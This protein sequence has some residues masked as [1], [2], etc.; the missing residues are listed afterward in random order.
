[1]ALLLFLLGGAAARAQCTIE[2]PQTGQATTEPMPQ[3]NCLPAGGS[4]DYTHTINFT[5]AVGGVNV[6]WGDGNFSLGVGGTSATHTYTAEGVFTYTI[7]GCGGTVEG[8]VVNIRQTNQIPKSRSITDPAG[9]V[10]NARCVPDDLTFDIQPRGNDWRANALAQYVVDWGDG[11]SEILDV[12]HFN[13]G[14]DGLPAGIPSPIVHTYLPDMAG[15]SLSVSFTY[16]NA[17]G[18][19]PSAPS[20]AT[21]GEYFFLDVDTAQAAPD[22][23]VICEPTDVTLNATPIFNCIDTLPR[24]IRW[25]AIEDFASPTCGPF[26]DFQTNP[27]AADPNVRDGFRPYATHQ[28]IDIPASCLL[29]VPA[30]STYLVRMILRNQCG[31][32][33]TTV[34]IIVRAP[35]QAVV[36]NNSPTCPGVEMEFSNNTPRRNEQRYVWDW[37]DGSDLETANGG[38]VR[39]L[40]ESGGDYWVK[41]TSVVNTSYGP[42]CSVVDSFQVS[43]LK[44][45]SPSLEVTPTKACDSITVELTNTSRF[46][47]GATW[48]DWSLGGDISVSPRNV[49]LPQPGT[50]NNNNDERR[51]IVTDPDPTDSSVTLTYPTWGRYSLRV[52]AQSGSCDPVWSQQRRVFVYP[53]PK[54]N[55]AISDTVLCFGNPLVI[56]DSSR[57]NV[58]SY[59]D[60]R[61]LGQ[62]AHHIEWALDFGGDSTITGRVR[63]SWD[64][65][66]T[67]DYYDPV[68]SDRVHS[69]TFADTGTYWVKIRVWTNHCETIDSVR[70]RVIP[71]AQPAFDVVQS[72]CNRSEFRLIN[73]TTPLPTTRYEWIVRRG[74]QPWDTIRTASA[75]DTTVILPHYGTQLLGLYRVRLRTVTGTD[76]TGYCYAETID[77]LLEVPQ[78]PV[79]LFRATPTAGCGDSLWV[80]FQNQSSFVPAG[81][82]FHWEFDNGQSAT[83]TE[84]DPVPGQWFLNTGGTPLTYTVRMRLYPDGSDPSC[85]Y[86]RT[87]DITVHPQAS[88]RIDGPATVCSGQPATFG[89]T[90]NF[91]NPTTL[92]WG[93]SVGGGGGTTFSPVFFNVT[94]APRTETI[95][96]SGLNL[97]GCPSTVTRVVTV[98]PT[99]DFNLNVTPAEACAGTPFNFEVEHDSLSAL[100]G[101]FT[102]FWR[103]GDGSVDTTSTPTAQHVYGNATAGTIPYAPEVTVI[104]ANGCEAIKSLTVRV[105]PIV[106]ADFTPRPDPVCSGEL[107]TLDAGAGA[108]RY[109]W[110]FRP[111][112]GTWS[113]PVTAGENYTPVPSPFVNGGTTPLDYEIR[114]R[115]SNSNGS[116]SDQA[117]RRIT[118]Q[119]VPVAAFTVTPDE[120]C[121]PLEVT[122]D[123]G[124]SQRGQRYLW[125][126]GDGTFDTTDTRTSVT[127]RYRNVGNLA[128]TVFV[129]LTVVADTAG[130]QC[131]TSTFKRVVVLPEVQADFDLSA[132]VGCDPLDV[133]F[134]NQSNAAVA[135][136]EWWYREVGA[137]N[138]DRV[139]PAAPM[140]FPFRSRSNT[141]TT[142]Y[143]IRLDVADASGTC[144]AQHFDTVAVLP[145]P[146]VQFTIDAPTECA[147][148]LATF[149]NRATAT[150]AGSRYEYFTKLST[151]PASAWQRF[152][153]RTTP[154]GTVERLFTNN[155][156]F[157]LEYDVKLVVTNP[158][159]CA[160][161]VLQRILV[162][163]FVRAS[164]R[165]DAAAG[166]E[167]LLVQFTNLSTASANSFEWDFDNPASGSAN[168]SE[169]RNPSHLFTEPGEYHVRLR[170]GT[171]N[172]A[173]TGCFDDTT[174]TIRVYEQPIADVTADRLTGCSGAPF[175]FNAAG[176]ADFDDLTWT[177][178]GASWTTSTARDTTFTFVNETNAPRT[179]VVRVAAQTAR[180]CVAFDSVQVIVQPAVAAAFDMNRDASC[181]PLEV[182][183]TENT[184]G[185]V[186]TWV[187]RFDH[188][189]F[190]PSTSTDRNPRASF[191]NPTDTLIRVPISLVVYSAAAQGC[192][193]YAYDTVEVYPEPRAQ[194][195]VGTVTCSPAA[196]EF[197]YLD[198]GPASAGER[199]EWFVDGTRQLA[200]TAAAAGSTVSLT[201]LNSTSDIRTFTVELR[202][203]NQWGCRTQYST[204]VDVPPAVTA[205]F[206]PVDAG[207]AP[208]RVEFEN[209]STNA[210]FFRWDFGNGP[211]SVS[212]D[213]NPTYTY[214]TPGTYTVTL[215]AWYQGDRNLDRCVQTFTQDIVVN[216]VPVADPTVSPTGAC[217]DFG[218][219]FGYGPGQAPGLRKVWRF[220]TNEVVTTRSDDPIIRSF[221]NNTS[222]P[223]DYVQWLYVYSDEGC[224][225]SASITVRVKPFVAAGFSMSDSVACGVL[226]TTFA[227][228]AAVSA[229]RFRWVFDYSFPNPSDSLLN[230]PNT[231]S[232]T[233]TFVNT[234]D[235]VLVVPVTLRAWRVEDPECYALYYDEVLIYPTPKAGFAFDPPGCTPATV[236]FDYRDARP[237]NGESYEWNFDGTTVVVDS[238]TAQA[239]LLPEAFTFTNPDDTIRA[240]PVTL[241]ARNRWGCDTV[242]TQIVY[243]Q[244]AITATVEAVEDAC[245]P[246]VVTFGFTQLSA[247]ARYFRWD[248][249]DGNWSAERTPT[250]RYETDRDTT[251]EATLTTWHR[252]DINADACVL[253]VDVPVRVLVKPEAVAQVTPLGCSGDAFRFEHTVLTHVD[254]LIW[255]F[256]D[257]ATLATTDPSAFVKVFTN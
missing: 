36:T 170:V 94:D 139:P 193:A 237:E 53:S 105:Q 169:L 143:E 30:D 29:P 3:Y 150:V 107:V 202:T 238:A 131:Q 189:V 214:G 52:R 6:D 19:D 83:L 196:V 227:N 140:G 32:D 188:P 145:K 72:T 129:T 213:R 67:L 174:I 101:S 192:R 79:A 1:M 178:D 112:G 163:P 137:T 236:R 10:E 223:Q 71:N 209:L 63:A 35:R 182:R 64:D 191:V 212:T 54:V 153:N 195:S 75:A 183:F 34:P 108:D 25:Q 106:S 56:R 256:S 7:S 244:P 93:S 31:D 225:D 146:E 45:V 121:S 206:A 68:S 224:V 18:L 27:S 226:T 254:S 91:L 87:Q 89:A 173:A 41:V 39:H 194:F 248:F 240:F 251:Y 97:F 2:D 118:V 198:R 22:P 59:E 155:E 252:A 205:A 167:D 62:E 57:V 122:F 117:V 216:E 116:C 179:V 134:I 186:D 187:W 38:T 250:H 147:D 148:V 151:A 161:S 138:W 96:L 156:T 37:G 120:G 95:T 86:E 246:S 203:R 211:G 184:T 127:H 242:G 199:Y 180:G 217:S 21:F 152:S 159:G 201:L 60:A 78:T 74:T 234:S 125:N 81:S 15:C 82:T 11:T 61:G 8:I 232:V 104:S 123:P 220:H 200:E 90:G 190:G 99:L 49:F 231:Q 219:R 33:T 162:K 70:V 245:E 257:G 255:H 55:W 50:Y 98:L 100:F 111:V 119:P 26:A 249:G 126:F 115:A 20:V 133:T 40:Y 172:S 243:V 28:S 233:R 43:V 149:D 114:L 235:T 204:T 102:Y 51:V 92:A 221:T 73:N 247:S 14:T 4:V 109:E 130:L 253:V 23:V 42:E 69:H 44:T 16:Q 165:P 88:L 13:L 47:A 46:T 222:T 181:T 9:G 135:N 17:C 207:C 208:L 141:D 229:N 5:A 171:T 185:P 128:Q 177:V 241:V 215:E 110:S 230:T 80:Q 176:S 218:F 65:A 228:E 84:N 103:W 77:S 132:R 166:C 85:F 144:T 142:W 58:T 12:R 124:G 168:R 113:T 197:T 76:S 66:D 154:S 48:L 239:G 158:Q 210:R 160:D 24:W 136:A 164:F 175:T 157:N